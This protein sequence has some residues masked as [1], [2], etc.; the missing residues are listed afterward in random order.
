MPH[1]KI[2]LTAVFAGMAMSALMQ[3]MLATAAPRI[4]EDLGGLGWYA[5]VFAAYMIASTATLPVFARWADRHGRRAMFVSGLSAYLA[6]TICCAVAGSMPELVAGRVLQGLGAG[7]LAPAAVAA[8]GDLVERD[9]RGR[10]FGAIGVVQVLATAS[11][12]LLGGFLADGPG[13]RWT[14]WTVLP[15]GVAAGVLGWLGLPGRPS[16]DENGAGSGGVVE[17]LRDPAMRAVAWTAV[18]LGFV[19]LGATAYL[20]LLA[21]NLLGISATGTAVVMVPLMVGVALGSALGGQLTGHP[22][23]TVTAAWVVVALGGAGVA[24][25]LDLGMLPIALASGALGLGVGT[26]QPVILL[27]AQDRV[28]RA[29][30]GAASGLVQLGR[31]LGAAVS[32]PLLGVWLALFT[33]ETGLRSI[34]ICLAVVAAAAGWLG[35]RL[36]TPSAN[37]APPTR[38]STR[39]GG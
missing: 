24:A 26:I 16:Q 30:A 13:W 29:H 8:L 28:G 31:N 39:A 38:R 12:P 9:R 14:M 33:L 15:F 17:L 2:G 35:R 27:G 18:A 19:M 21:Q 6:G 36:P 11:G 34:F 25:L 22:R 5:W 20:P 23:T 3:T 7:A 10:V 4:V 1:P 37:L 32:T